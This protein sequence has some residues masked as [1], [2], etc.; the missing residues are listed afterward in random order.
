MLSEES[1]QGIKVLGNINVDLPRRIASKDSEVVHLT[2]IE[3]RFL[4]YWL[5]I[6]EGLS[7]KNNYS[8]KVWTII[9]RK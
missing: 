2:P 6:Q 9:F 3:F 8:K 4:L 5:K 1:H 7:H